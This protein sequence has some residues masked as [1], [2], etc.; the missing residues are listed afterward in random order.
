MFFYLNDKKLEIIKRF[1]FELIID[2]NLIYLIFNFLYFFLNVFVVFNVN[3]EN[4]IYFCYF[5][6][7]K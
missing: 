3:L 1:L 6:R 7:F 2:L 5:N 4:E